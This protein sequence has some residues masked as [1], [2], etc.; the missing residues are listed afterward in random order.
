MSFVG[1]FYFMCGNIHP[2]YRASVRAIHL[3]AVAKS[4]D[5]RRFG[6]DVLLQPFI[7]QVN[8]LG[9]VCDYRG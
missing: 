9:K 2:V 3:I 4:M 5:I 6:C 1:V 8:L 7:E